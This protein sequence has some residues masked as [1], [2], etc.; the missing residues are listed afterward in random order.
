MSATGF[1]QRTCLPAS[2]AARAT[3][4]ASPPE[5]TV[6]TPVADAAKLRRVLERMLDELIG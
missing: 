2:R 5:P 4:V 1:S 6:A 3:P